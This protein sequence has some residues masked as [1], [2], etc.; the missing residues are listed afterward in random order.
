MTQIPY[1]TYNPTAAP[2][3]SAVVPFAQPPIP[4]EI[5]VGSGI[6]NLG[7]AFAAF[8]QTL[9]SFVANRVSADREKA[10]MEGEAKV[11]K[12]RKTF[13]QL[14]SSG[15]ITPQENPWEA[16]GAAAADG[17]LAAASFRAKAKAEYDDKLMKDPNFATSV[18]A[19]EDFI[20]SKLADEIAA[21][22]QN[23]VWQRSFLKEASPFASHLGAVHGDNVAKARRDR[24][25]KALSVGVSSDV[26]LM[27]S[28]LKNLSPSDPAY[29]NRVKSTTQ[30]IQA[31]ID[32]AYQ[33]VGPHAM[34]RFYDTLVSLEE[35]YGSDPAVMAVIRSVKSGTGPAVKTE[36]Y[37]A[38]RAEKSDRIEAA[39]LSRDVGLGVDF[40]V[41]RL[42]ETG[43]NGE[44]AEFPSFEEFKDHY[45]ER[46]RPDASTPEV[47]KIYSAVSSKSQEFRNQLFDTF[48]NNLAENVTTLV[49]SAY[50]T[51][52]AESIRLRDPEALKSLV[53]DR[54]LPAM[55]SLNIQ[56]DPQSM[57]S[58]VELIAKQA[59]YS[60]QSRILNS[61]VVRSMPPTQK[62]GTIV[63]FAINTGSSIQ[64]MPNI[65]QDIVRFQRNPGSDTFT[66]NIAL[67]LYMYQNAKRQGAD[68]AKLGFRK[69]TSEFF[70][71]MD[72]EAR[73]GNSIETAATNAS[74][75][76]IWAPDL[77][78]TRVQKISESVANSLDG[79][80][81]W[82]STATQQRDDL[83]YQAL[84]RVNG[85]EM[86]ML[87]DDEV[88]TRVVTEIQN[89]SVRTSSG[90]ILLNPTDPLVLRDSDSWD[91]LITKAKE[92][93]G[94]QGVKFVRTP[95][96]TYQMFMTTPENPYGRLPDI[97]E[98]EALESIGVGG[99]LNSVEVEQWMLKSGIQRAV[100][101][102]A[103]RL[104]FLKRNRF[105]R[106]GL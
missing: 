104:E 101:E 48:R 4:Q 35:T 14:V 77:P 42:Q 66:Q 37:R 80:F 103:V 24:M 21:G 17:V 74:F 82:E 61:D 106:G 55:Q 8:S 89:N 28:E 51:D 19:G 49:E 97:E 67:G 93:T 62:A 64:V 5:Q 63:D 52:T 30:A 86:D 1:A 45:L 36:E 38:A 20:N 31:R 53:R 27:Q 85:P 68:L 12:S 87:T 75:G 10:M 84:A 50:L 72:S 69:T 26:E 73:K 98:L 11:M 70:S 76:V 40:V 46:V 81:T 78:A 57:D 79:L 13:R 18:T 91:Y 9:A 56:K 43:P 22:L 105:T 33:T 92:A 32:E 44:P 88:A 54:L 83:F 94:A 71:F 90:H 6:E 41:D 59:A 29:N 100:E 15:E 47:V 23:P 99:N 3:Q 7:P 95:S 58:M 2:V 60:A 34:D 65:E 16:V 96:G 102:E 25:D 39:R